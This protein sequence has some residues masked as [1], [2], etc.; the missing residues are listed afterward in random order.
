MSLLTSKELAE[1]NRLDLEEDQVEGFRAMTDHFRLVILEER[2]PGGIEKLKQLERRR[3]QLM[4]ELERIETDMAALPMPGVMHLEPQVR[5]YAYR[6]G[7]PI[8]AVRAYF[9]QEMGG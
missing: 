5:I 3:D 4:G 1:A 6:S 9:L 2:L 7:E 8:D